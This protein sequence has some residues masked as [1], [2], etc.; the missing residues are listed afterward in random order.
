MMM[1]AR[2]LTNLGDILRLPDYGSRP[3]YIDQRDS[4]RP[5]SVTAL[6]LDALIAAVARG[7]LRRGIEPGDRVGIL[8]ENRL[9]FV[10]AYFGIM[11]MG[12]VA[13]PVNYKLP[14]S[15]VADILPRQRATH[16]LRRRSAVVSSARRRVV[17]Q[18]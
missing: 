12:A 15:T 3:A 7:L 16:R 9:E 10:A 13:V 11:R 1:P 8:A 2:T 17:H 6:E 14:R 4:L 18:L 5:R